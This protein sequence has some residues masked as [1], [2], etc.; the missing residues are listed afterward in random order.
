MKLTD[1]IEK[2]VEATM[3]SLDGISR[4]TANPFLYTRIH[5][6]L[7]AE[8]S[9]F[10]ARLAAFMTKPTVAIATVLVIL[11]MNS[12]IFL[13]NS[14]GNTNRSAVASQDEDQ[15]L[16]REYAVSSLSEE[17]IYTLNEEQP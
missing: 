7:T 11:L 4:A 13:N 14:H 9:G 16:S 17:N 3:A 1:N 10:W 5:A 2:Q 15:L 12:V 8:E 6:S